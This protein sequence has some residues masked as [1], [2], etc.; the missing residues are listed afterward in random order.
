MSEQNKAIVRRIFEQGMNQNKTSVFDDLIAHN[1][2][3]HNMPAPAPGPEGFKQVLAMFTKAFPDMKVTL[4]E[5]VGEGDKVSTRGKFT[6]SHKGEFMGIPATGKKITVTYI[7]IWRIQ[8]GKAVEN[9]VQ[10]DM[11]GM[12]QQLGVAPPPPGQQR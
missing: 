8:N 6:G 9:W 7:D 5:V 2:V 12:M 1:Y 10:M 3:N 11:M 4:D